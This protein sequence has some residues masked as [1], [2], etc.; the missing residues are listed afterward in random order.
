[1]PRDRAA[2]LMYW[3][4]PRDARKNRADAV[5]AMFDCAGFATLGIDVTLV[6]PHVRRPEYPVAKSEVWRQY[7]LRPLFRICELPTWFT[8]R[9]SER[10]VRLQKLLAGTAFALALAARSLIDRRVRFF[11]V[12]CP[13][14]SA[15]FVF[16]ARAV[17]ALGW[18]CFL[19]LGAFVEPREVERR[20]AQACDGVLAGNDH[21]YTG[22]VDYYGV[23]PERVF[24]QWPYSYLEILD[25]TL[26]EPPPV[27]DDRPR[28]VYVGKIGYPPHEE[29]QL[30]VE[31][32]R[33]MP[34][35]RFVFVG[36]NGES[37]AAWVSRAE[38]LG[39]DATWLGFQPLPRLLPLVRSA[40]AL[41]SYYPSSD[42]LVDRNRI[43]A[44]FALYRCAGKPIVA[45]DFPGIREV[46]GE[47]EAWF[48]PPDRPHDLAATLR[49][50]LTEPAAAAAKGA[51]ALE[52]ARRRNV[53]RY[54]ADA[55][56]FMRTVAALPYTR[57]P[58][59]GD[60]L[61]STAKY[62]SEP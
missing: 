18:H 31:T 45:A 9:S 10:V 8:D 30:L 19:T 5:R 4:S 42:S 36:G 39:V 16:L 50:A 15:P 60:G 32:A 29:I 59:D 57:A 21:I 25:E 48:V 44:K 61:S 37:E 26:E 52:H 38:Q 1:M 51:A 3:I 24:R 6:T 43:P 20:M 33:L 49:R 11:V 41:V 46:L 7:G 47:D 53:T 27:P 62:G 56:A 14:T 28:V 40:A 12:H 34:E 13:A 17:P 55:L 2:P 54:C 35:L 58:V 23:A 22:F